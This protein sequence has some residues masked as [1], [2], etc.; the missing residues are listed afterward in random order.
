MLTMDERVRAAKVK[1]VLIV[2]MLAWVFTH[3]GLK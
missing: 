3:G 2:L 1:L